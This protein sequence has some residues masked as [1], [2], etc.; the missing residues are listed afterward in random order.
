MRVIIAAFLG[1]CIGAI[2]DA[3]A[4]APEEQLTFGAGVGITIGVLLLFFGIVG[5]ALPDF[6]A[7]RKKKDNQQ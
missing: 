5:L 1:A 7:S 6:I 4:A 3:I 2:L